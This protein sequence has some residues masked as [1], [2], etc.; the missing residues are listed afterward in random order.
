MKFR[1]TFDGGWRPDLPADVVGG[2][3][4]TE[5]ED[6]VREASGYRRKL[7]WTSVTTGGTQALDSECK[8]AFNA[9][10]PFGGLS[11]TNMVSYAATQNYIYAMGLPSAGWIDKTPSVWGGTSGLPTTTPRTFCQYGDDVFFTCATSSADTK[12]ALMYSNVGGGTQFA[13]VSA[14]APQAYN[15]AVVGQHLVLGDFTDQAYGNSAGNNGLWW[16]AIGN[17]FSWPE[18]G[19]ETAVAAQSDLRYLSKSGGR[20]HAIIGKPDYGIVLQK[21]AI[22]VMQYVGGAVQYEFRNI[23]NDHGCYIRHM[24]VDTPVGVLFLDSDGFYLCDGNTVTPVGTGKTRWWIMR[25][26]RLADPDDWYRCTINVDYRDRQVIFAFPDDAPHASLLWRTDEAV[27]WNWELDEWV[28]WVDDVN[29]LFIY[30]VSQPYPVLAQFGTDNKL[31]ILA[32]SND[33]GV[34]A[35]G[36]VELNPDGRATVLR[37]RPLAEGQTYDDTMYGYTGSTLEVASRAER[38]DALVWSDPIDLNSYGWFDVRAD[39]RFHRFRLKLSGGGGTSYSANQWTG[40]W[41]A[42]G[43]DVD[44]EVSGG[45]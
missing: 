4:L 5:C 45:R 42:T 44:Y 16:S 6:V 20:I 36:D 9:Q 3:G 38:S 31:D 7:Q 32:G 34:M 8:G 41:I 24:A 28:H 15:M 40:S 1:C 19:T 33:T 22:W 39:G 17:P 25:W 43:L 26:L 30:E 37:V 2:N 18:P 11:S 14:N 23:S 13:P 21:K 29:R 27:V 12:Y 10:N 35:T